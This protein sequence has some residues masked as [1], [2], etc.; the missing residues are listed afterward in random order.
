MTVPLPA[1]VLEQYERATLYNSPYP[2]HR[3]GRAVDLYPGPD[4][5]DAVPGTPGSTSRA[6]SPVAGEVR[7]TRSVAAPDR[8]YAAARDHLLVV[9]VDAPEAVAGTVARLLHVEPA[10]TPGDRVEIGDSLGSL[11]RSGYF[12]PWVDNHLHLGFREPDANHLR[13]TGSLRLR[14][15]VDVHPV[16]W[17]GTG[18][19]VETGDTY[20]VLDAPAHPDPG[21]WA[22]IATASGPVLDGGLPHY[23]GGGLIGGRRD[24]EV[25]LLD[26]AVGTAVGRDV[27]WDDVTVLANGEPV[28]GLSLFLA[29]DAEFGA[30]LVTP[31][32]D[33][34]A[35]EDVAV[36][37]ER[38]ATDG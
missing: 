3:Q 31:D 5:P 10:V 6:P 35:G 26:T 33:L 15:G 27:A 18:T 16:A 23:D 12:A 25:R 36:T 34:E 2:A 14:F 8:P 21:T 22:G 20:A 1:S 38:T 37:L 11:V 24:G 13:A 30:K 4:G 29:R 7:A 17:D 32:T 28:T 9:E 19:V